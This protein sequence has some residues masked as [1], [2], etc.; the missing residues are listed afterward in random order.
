MKSPAIKKG[1]SKVEVRQTFRT[2]S[3]MDSS[4]EEASFRIAR[5]AAIRTLSSALDQSSRHICV[6]KR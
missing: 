6:P 5:N 1:S 4:V 3:M 2:M